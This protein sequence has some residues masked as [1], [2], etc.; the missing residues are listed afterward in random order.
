MKNYTFWLKAA[1]IMQFLTAIVHSI[2]LFTDPIPENDKEKELLDLMG[3][4]KLDFGAGFHRTM[5]EIMTPLSA[6][7]S[8]LCLLGGLINW[9]ILQKK[10]SSEVVKGIIT[11]NLIVFGICFGLI[12]V[13]AF[14]PPIIM[15]GL[16][17]VFLG[18]SLITVPKIH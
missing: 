1:S 14:L 3:T 9:Y 11:F 13:Y 2:S 8:L 12:M 16:I 10:V 15:T 6:C 5:N 4:Y 17:F 18:V 7:L